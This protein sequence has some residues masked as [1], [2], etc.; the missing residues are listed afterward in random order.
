M[1]TKLKFLT[2]SRSLRGNFTVNYSPNLLDVRWKIFRY[3]SKA[4]KKKRKKS[5]CVDTTA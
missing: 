1:V 5:T 3:R 2:G 4:K